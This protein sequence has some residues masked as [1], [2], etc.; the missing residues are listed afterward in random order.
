[1]AN[2]YTQIYI[3]VIYAVQGS[4]NPL[5]KEHKEELHNY[6]TGIVRNEKQKMIAINSM[7]DHVHILI[8]LGPSLAL[9]DLIAKVKSNSSLFINE[10]K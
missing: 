4:Q 7:P 10:K 1:M 8:G 6:I 3:Q 2:T 5:R 9:S